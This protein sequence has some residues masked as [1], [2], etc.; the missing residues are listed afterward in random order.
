MRLK[1][2]VAKT[3]LMRMENYDENLIDLWLNLMQETLTK[4]ISKR[5]RKQ[6][7]QKKKKD[8]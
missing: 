6:Q 1:G 8:E 3:A 2:T 7:E 4:H 5:K